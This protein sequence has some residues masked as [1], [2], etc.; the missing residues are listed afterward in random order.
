MGGIGMLFPT[1]GGIG[2]YHYIVMMSLVLLQVPNGYVNTNF[3]EYDNYNS[4]LLFP[5]I[6]WFA[7]SFVAVFLG[8]ISLFII[9]LSKKKKYA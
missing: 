7:Q 8:S 5:T 4:A 2:S 1:P 3:L 9:F 6:V